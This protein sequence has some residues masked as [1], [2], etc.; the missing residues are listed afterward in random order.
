MNNSASKSVILISGAT[1]LVG[2]Y[3]L[4][5]LLK[6]GHRV[7][8]LARSKREKVVYDEARAYN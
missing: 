6:N 1:G 8:T 2:S 3:L 4:K 5:I 7:F